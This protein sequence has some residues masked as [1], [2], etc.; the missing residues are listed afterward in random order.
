MRRL[1]IVTLTTA[2]AGILLV[3]CGAGD[4]EEAVADETAVAAET[5]AAVEGG[6]PPVS[7]EAIVTESGL[8][9][10]D[11]EVGSGDEVQPGQTAVVHYTGWLADGTKF[12]SS[13]DRGEP[14]AFPVGAGRVIRGWDEG[15]VGM[16]VGGKRRLIIPPELAY[17]SRGVPQAGIPPDAQ[18]TFDVELLE[19]R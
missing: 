17:G 10:I 19:V 11:V 14:F 7:G 3:A 15:V 9:I 2:I 18:L 16:K 6:P 12:D 1:L 5:E 8:Q 4:G 13:L